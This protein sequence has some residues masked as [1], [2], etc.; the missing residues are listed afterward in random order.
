MAVPHFGMRTQRWFL[1]V[2]LLPFQW[3]ID[4]QKNRGPIADPDFNLNNNK[5]SLIF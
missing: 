1:I 5:W 3:K 2:K 4:Q